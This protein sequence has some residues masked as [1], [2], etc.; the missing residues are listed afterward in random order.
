MMINDNPDIEYVRKVIDYATMVYD[1]DPTRIFAMG[2]AL[3][4][5]FVNMVG[6]FV[7]MDRLFG[8]AFVTIPAHLGKI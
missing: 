7:L 5:D 2:T 3:G 4:G 1:I 6:H 8:H